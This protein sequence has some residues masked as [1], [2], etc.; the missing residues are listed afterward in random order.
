MVKLVDKETLLKEREEKK[1]VGRRY[2]AYF[3]SLHKDVITVTE[4]NPTGLLLKFLKI[5][6]VCTVD[7]AELPFLILMP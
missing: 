6:K 4:M 1:K 7:E 2:A 5:G 3:N